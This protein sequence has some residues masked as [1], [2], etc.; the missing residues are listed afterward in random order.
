ARL[1]LRG[2]P[3][4]TRRRSRLGRG[5][6][7]GRTPATGTRDTGGAG[8]AGGRTKTGGA[9]V[10]TGAAAGTN[11][12]VDHLW[13]RYGT[14]ADAVRQLVAERPDLAEPIVPGLPYVGAEVVYAAR[15]EMAQ[16]LED[17]LSRRT[18]ALLQQARGSAAVAGRVAALMAPELGWTDEQAADQ[19][20]STP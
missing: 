14:E 5:G 15:A 19:A 7:A 18:R 1:T 16:S 9:A 4:R 20:A 8:N 10:G 2:A 17:V 13:T 3:G 11:G 6:Q 12:G